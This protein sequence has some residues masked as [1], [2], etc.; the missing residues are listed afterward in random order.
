MEA[1]ARERMEDALKVLAIQGINMLVAHHIKGADL[2]KKG[3][4]TLVMNE[5]DIKDY[6]NELKEIL[7]VLGPIFDVVRD[8]IAK[9]YEHLLELW[10]WA[11]D[12]YHEIFG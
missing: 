6:W 9:T 2:I 12:K 3:F 1:I 8:W 4:D 5:K 11:K 7:K 10:D